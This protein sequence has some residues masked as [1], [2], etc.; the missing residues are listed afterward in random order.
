[1]SGR[2]PGI[3]RAFSRQ[4]REDGKF[5]RAGPEAMRD[6]PHEWDKVE[7]A[8]DESFSASDPPAYYPCGSDAA[9]PEAKSC[10]ANDENSCLPDG[11]RERR[12]AKPSCL[13]R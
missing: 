3:R 10:A 7:E 1:M 6:P 4:G 9:K 12:A 13:G 8:P 2:S 5:R 11:P